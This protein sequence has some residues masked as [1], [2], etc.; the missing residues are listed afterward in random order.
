MN[1]LKIELTEEQ[2][3]RALNFLGSA[4]YMEVADI[5]DEIKY[6]ANQQ[7]TEGEDI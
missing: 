7:L 5:I 4:P 3:Q 2:I 1:K 6:Q